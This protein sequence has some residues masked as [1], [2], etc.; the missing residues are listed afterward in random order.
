MSDALVYK[1]GRL[2]SLCFRL[3]MSGAKSLVPIRR[4]ARGVP[5]DIIRHN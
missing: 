3:V 5:S 1:M 4:D 2:E